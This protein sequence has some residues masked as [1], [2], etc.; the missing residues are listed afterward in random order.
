MTETLQPLRIAVIGC[1][2]IAPTHIESFQALDGVCISW[3]CDIE[4]S[5]AENLAD[6]YG[7]GQTA[8][9]YRTV[10]DANDVDCISIC[11]DHASHA[12]IAMDALDAGRHVLCEKALGVSAYDMDAMLAAHARH[13]Q[14]VFGGVFQHRFDPAYLR[15]KQMVEQGLFGSILTAGIQLRCRRTSDYYRA[16]QWRG[17]WAMEGGS[18]LMNQAIHYIDLLNWITGG[19][20]A[21]CGA[22]ANLTHGGMIETEDTA[23]ASLRFK[24]GALGTLEVTC[25]SHLDWDPVLF[26][27]GTDGFVE[28]RRDQPVRVEFGNPETD[29]AIE[30]SLREVSSPGGVLAGKDYYGAGH[31]SQI[32]DFVSA[33]R[34]RREPFVTAASARV[35][36]DIALAI[37]QSHQAGGWV[38]LSKNRGESSCT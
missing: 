21:L 26:I 3:L 37:Y 14:Q 24:N 16:D 25:S 35:A 27:Q 20:D 5:R 15:L 6:Q 11:T 19:I 22:H 12:R 9:D 4:A 18:V 2:V 29:R 13:P 33:V 23:V 30:A 8:T 34:E 36:V 28:I 38:T 7:I 17:T 32:A 1:G 31:R 10:L